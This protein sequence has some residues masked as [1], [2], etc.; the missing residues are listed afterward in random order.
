MRVGWLALVLTACLGSAPSQ[1]LSIP[2]DM[3]APKVDL[4][5]ADYAGDYD[6]SQLNACI[7]DP[8]CI[9]MLCQNA[10]HA[11]ATPSANQKDQALQD[12]LRMNCPDNAG[13]ICAP[14]ANGNRSATCKQC[15]ANAEAN[16]SQSCTPSDAAECHQC[17]MQ[18]QA[19]LT[20]HT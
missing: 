19:C 15:I 2:A 11:M 1:D 7:S 12:C 20:D 4:Y 17:S 13:A 10:C 16:S 9:N 8:M 3:S 14:D 6:C 5:G 18:T